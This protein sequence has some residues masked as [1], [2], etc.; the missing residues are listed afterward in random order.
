MSTAT[1]FRRESQQMGTVIYQGSISCMEP[2]PSKISITRVVVVVLDEWYVILLSEISTEGIR[3]KLSSRDHTVR[4]PVTLNPI[5]DL[6][7]KRLVV[8]E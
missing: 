2:T 6:L 3:P 1:I 7:S 5:M 4:F 8:S